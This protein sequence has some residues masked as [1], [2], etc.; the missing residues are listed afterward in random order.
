MSTPLELLDNQNVKVQASFLPTRLFPESEQDADISVTNVSLKDNKIDFDLNLSNVQFADYSSV[1]L[2]EITPQ[3][4]T[5]L[6]KEGFPN[7]LSLKTQ[8][9]IFGNDKSTEAYEPKAVLQDINVVISNVQDDVYNI[10]IILEDFPLATSDVFLLEIGKDQILQ[11][12][13]TKE[14][15]YDDVFSKSDLQVTSL[16]IKENDTYTSNLIYS[17]NEDGVFSGLFCIDLEKFIFDFAKFPNLLF[18]KDKS[19]INDFIYKTSLFL[20]RYD[21]AKAGYKFADSVV[22]TEASPVD[23]LAVSNSSPYRFYDFS[24]GLQD[25]FSQMQAVA[26]IYFNDVT[27]NLAKESLQTLITTRNNNN[28]ELA[29]DTIDDIYDDEFDKNFD[30]DLD[31]ILKISNVEYQEILG[32]VI[33]QLSDRINDASQKVVVNTNAAS[34]YTFPK[35]SFSDYYLGVF[36]QKFEQ[37]IF[38]GRKKSISFLFEETETETGVNNFPVISLDDALDQK[39]VTTSQIKSFKMVRSPQKIGKFIQNSKRDIL[40]SNQGLQEKVNISDSDEKSLNNLADLPKEK[41]IDFSSFKDRNVKIFY[42]S[43]VGDTS[44]VLLFSEVGENLNDI[45]NQNNKIL[46][47]LDNYEEFYNSY[48]YV[49]QDAG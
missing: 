25:E 45:I 41:F 20:Y 33:H 10:L 28:R 44:P 18:G 6:N 46:I 2:M 15:K 19:V 3:I 32:K 42:L 30:F 11:Q 34:Q 9:I 17:Y 5:E 22:Q 36:E 27:I 35:P 38:L 7:K 31:T 23:N 21:G 43:S 26:K 1:K 47:R 16:K 4:A 24:I 29:R 14:E 37:K 8:E 13:S 39:I 40:I 49:T 48:F 12:K